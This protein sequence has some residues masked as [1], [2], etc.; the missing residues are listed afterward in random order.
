[1]R[2]DGTTMWKT[3]EEN[4]RE[5]EK[6]SKRRRNWKKQIAAA[7]FFVLLIILMIISMKIMVKTADVVVGKLWIGTQG[8]VCGGF[9]HFWQTE[10]D[11][12]DEDDFGSGGAA[13]GQPDQT[14]TTSS[15]L[16]LLF[17]VVKCT[18]VKMAQGCGRKD[19]QNWRRAAKA[20]EMM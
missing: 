20:N 18:L 4:H 15:L 9:G 13:E 10:K 3:G 12:D 5:G 17:F 6:R 8:G 14:T 2:S 7:N 19:G 1:M 11:N 16:F